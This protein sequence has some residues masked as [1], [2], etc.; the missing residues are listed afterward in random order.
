MAGMYVVLFV[1][2]NII[3][4]EIRARASMEPHLF[5]IY[6]YVLLIFFTIFCINS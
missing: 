4:H 6:D 1:D 5:Y 3:T 2:G